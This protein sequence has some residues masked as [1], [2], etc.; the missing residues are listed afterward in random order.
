MAGID[1]TKLVRDQNCNPV[2]PWNFV[3]DNTIFG[4]IHGAGGY[5]AW[6]DKHASYSSVGGPTGT[7]VDSNVDDYYSPEINSDS[8]NFASEAPTQLVIP[9]CAKSGAAYLPD[10][11]EIGRASCR[12]RV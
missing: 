3:R 12:E 4:V 5:T 11:L 9:A 2:Y 8:A 10:Q 6:S 7:S 1:S